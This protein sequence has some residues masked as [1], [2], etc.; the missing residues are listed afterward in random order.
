MSEGWVRVCV[1]VAFSPKSKSWRTYEHCCVGSAPV[2][3]SWARLTLSRKGLVTL[4]RWAEP[5]V[6]SFCP[7]GSWDDDLDWALH[8]RLSLDHL[9]ASMPFRGAKIKSRTPWLECSGPGASWNTEHY[10]MST[11]PTRTTIVVSRRENREN[12]P[13]FR[14]PEGLQKQGPLL[15]ETSD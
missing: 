9:T 8:W 10:W 7:L 12:Q 6:W 1:I 2:F 15:A 13:P 5:T 11:A 14:T 3:C 4:L